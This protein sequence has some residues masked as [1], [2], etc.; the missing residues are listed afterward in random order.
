M[1][2]MN[3]IFGF[4]KK[5]LLDQKLRPIKDAPMPSGLDMHP[6]HRRKFKEVIKRQCLVCT[7]PLRSRV[8]FPSVIWLQI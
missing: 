6:D 2:P 8:V 1:M 5:Y 3:F 4:A 7:T